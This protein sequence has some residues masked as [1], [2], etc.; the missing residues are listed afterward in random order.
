[1]RKVEFYGRAENFTIEDAGGLKDVSF[2]FREDD[3]ED[4]ESFK[5]PVFAVLAGM[6]RIEIDAPVCSEPF[7]CESLLQFSALKTSV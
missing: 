4:A 3:A 7:D 2:C 1:M 5:L 6:E